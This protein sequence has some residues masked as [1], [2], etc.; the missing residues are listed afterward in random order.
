MDGIL[1][2]GSTNVDL[3]ATTAS[4][5]SPG[6]TVLGE[7]F[8]Q[9]RGGKG[10]NQAVAAS[11]SGGSVT[12]LTAIGDDLYGRECLDGFAAEEIETDWIQ[13]I[14][15]VST[16]VALIT[17]DSRG[18]NCIVVT[19]GA[20]AALT[21]K[22]IQAGFS[23]FS[24]IGVCVCQLETPLDGIWSA[25]SLARKAGAFTILNPAP[26][27]PLDD[28]LLTNVDCLTPNQTEAEL[29][30][31]IRPESTK[32]AQIA[33]ERLLDR[34]V[35]AVIITMGARGAVLV[36]EEGM[37]HQP[38]P[39]VQTVDSTAAGDTFTGCLAARI[40][41]GQALRQALPYACCAGALAVTVRG[42]QPAIPTRQQI[43]RLA[44][45]FLPKAN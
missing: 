2:V 34:G 15:G 22:V 35:R 26:A 19:P 30:T 27:Q 39:A 7:H 23:R 14:P 36:D 21:D 41:L 17:V 33:A 9:A 10:A 3:I 5:P 38:S 44:S 13:C 42:A 28:D 31:G 11:R 43:E 12:V 16:G 4:L 32:T 24:G 29:L 6:E 1:V 18:E 40:A 25:L 8:L 37:I 20:N 45:D